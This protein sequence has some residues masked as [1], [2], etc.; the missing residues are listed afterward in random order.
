MTEQE[1]EGGRAQGRVVEISMDGVK[2]R[3]EEV[4][5]GWREKAQCV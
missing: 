4:G 2:K 1:E 5:G 3:L